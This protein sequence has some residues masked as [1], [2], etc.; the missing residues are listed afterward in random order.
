MVQLMKRP[1]A[2]V[3]AAPAEKKAKLAPVQ[4]EKLPKRDKRFDEVCEGI[5][6]VETLPESAMEMLTSML[7]HALGTCK[8]SR[9]KYQVMVV[10]MIEKIFRDWE[11]NLEKQ[12]EEYV[13]S[14]EAIT[15]QQDAA[16]GIV[17][18]RIEEFEA[19]QKE[20]TA[21]KNELAEA[22]IEFR[23]ARTAVEELEMEQA[24]ANV[25]FDRTVKQKENLE[26]CLE[27]NL[28]PLLSQGGTTEEVGLFVDGLQKFGFDES[29]LIALPGALSK[30]PD[31]RTPFDTLVLN[32]VEE[33][34]G[35][36]LVNFE[37]TIKGAEPA[38]ASR[39]QTMEQA[40]A[41]LEEAKKLQVKRAD[42]YTKASEQDEVRNTAVKDAKKEVSAFGQQANK[43]KR[44]MEQTFRTLRMFQTGPKVAFES[45]REKTAP[46]EPQP[47]EA[48]EADLHNVEE[49]EPPKNAM[50]VESAVGICVA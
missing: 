22:A 46:L 36:R 18:Q 30:T 14:G 1:A 12:Y 2:H 25:E 8:E 47:I 5:Q 40:N 23:S 38:R 32:Q 13:T 7:E 11:A 21:R 16:R 48:G 15:A 37:S 6:S 33:E 24:T 20:T 41:K 9:D 50:E 28:R 26:T 34:V 27:Q 45:L 44:L 31:A 42:E 4:K 10:D 49:L 43:E 39:L 3:N 35:K 19:Q 17:A 29:M